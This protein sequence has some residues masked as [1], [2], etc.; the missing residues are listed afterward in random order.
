MSYFPGW[1]K[2]DGKLMLLLSD[3]VSV[4]FVPDQEGTPFQAAVGDASFACQSLEEAVDWCE[5]VYR[6]MNVLL[7]T[8]PLSETNPYAEQEPD[9]DTR[10]LEERGL[11]T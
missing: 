5:Q 4:S 6:G 9:A 11:K 1:K 2:E 3:D 10:F 8:E 7:G